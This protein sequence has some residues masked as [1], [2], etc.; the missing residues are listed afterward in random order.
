MQEQWKAL[1][2][3]QLEQAILDI[4]RNI[5]FNT[6]KLKHKRAQIEALRV[7]LNHLESNAK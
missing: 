2:K 4:E 6:E 1:A 3:R 7:Q 5:E